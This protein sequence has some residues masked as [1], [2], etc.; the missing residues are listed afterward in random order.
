[1]PKDWI[2]EKGSDIGYS[3]RSMFADGCDPLVPPKYESDEDKCDST[4]VGL[5]MENNN[6]AITE[7][8][9]SLDGGDLTPEAIE[10]L[11]ELGITQNDAGVWTSPIRG[12]LTALA[13][14]Y[15]GD[16]GGGGS[17]L[18]SHQTGS[19]GAGVVVGVLADGSFG[20]VN[21]EDSGAVDREVIAHM[22][23]PPGDGLGL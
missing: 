3:N 5:V 22:D 4:T 23:C 14:A 19:A 9:D 13:S 15:S 6:S 10:A 16:L 17:G 1:M 12:D 21:A 8:I 18:G 20:L 11:G 7:I 2:Q